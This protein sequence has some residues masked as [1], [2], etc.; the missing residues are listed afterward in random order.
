MGYERFIAK[1]YLTARRKQAFISVITVISTAGIAIGVAALI[2]AV[3][4]ITGF[5]RD[6]QNKIL[7][8]TSHLMVSEVMGEGLA[9]YETVAAKIRPMPGVTS[10]SPVAYGM[11]LFQGPSKSQGAMLKGMDLAFETK[12]QPW[13]KTLESGALPEKKNGPR[14]GILLGRDLAFSIGAGVGDIVTVVTA[15]SRIGPLGMVPRVKPFQVTGIFRTGLY[16]FDSTTA[17]A[18]L[19]AAQRFLGL[20][21]RVSYLQVMIRDIFAAD[22]TK[23]ELKSIL[24]PLA[25]VTT[26]TELNQSLF[27]ALRL[28]KNIIFLTITLIVIVAALNIIATLILMVMEKTRDIGVLMA[29]GA[30]PAAIRKIFFIQGAMIGIVGTAIGTALGLLW[31]LVA[32]AFKLIRVPVDIYQ[33]PYVPFRITIL[34]LLV[35]IGVSLAISFLST[36]FPSH[37]AAKIDPVTALKYE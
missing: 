15:S 31:C 33:I 2:I 34:D 22:R 16:E 12:Q 32:N 3:A 18:D 26:W 5:Q 7:G 37:R 11:V 27:S 17:L 21:D 1:R 35:I 24:P 4:L 6:V 23:A 9:D 36:L 29:L 13:L 30:T 28:E 8:A 20:G 19:S 14:E 10:V 25:Y